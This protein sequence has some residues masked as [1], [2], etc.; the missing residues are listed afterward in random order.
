M[1]T[2]NNESLSTNSS[3]AFVE[4]VTDTFCGHVISSTVRPAT[5][6]DIDIAKE[7][8]YQG[9]CP[10]NIVMDERGWMYDFRSCFICGKGLGTV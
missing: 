10:H 4:T 6:S 9:K 2:I 3:L 5:E 8:Y 7:L 1:D